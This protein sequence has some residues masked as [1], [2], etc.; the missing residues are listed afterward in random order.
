MQFP[1]AVWGISGRNE[2]KQR[3]HLSTFTDKAMLSEICF[4]YVVIVK[5]RSWFTD[6]GLF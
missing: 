1:Q 2:C 4:H 6:T 3:G 5:A